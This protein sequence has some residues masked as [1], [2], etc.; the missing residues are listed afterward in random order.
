MTAYLIALL[1]VWLWWCLVFAER[2]QFT[3]A[4]V[5]PF[6][7]AIGL[8]LLPFALIAKGLQRAMSWVLDHPADW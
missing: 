3:C 7:F 1:S 2:K 6:F 5:A 4:L 8:L